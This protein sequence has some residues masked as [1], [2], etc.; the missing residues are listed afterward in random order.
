MEP[1]ITKPRMDR[2][3]ILD[4][5]HENVSGHERGSVHDSEPFTSLR[6]DAQL[7]TKINVYVLRED[8]PL[9]RFFQNG[10]RGF[11]VTFPTRAEVSEGNTGDQRNR[12]LIIKGCP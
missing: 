6:V 11:N 8:K 5:F 2:N 1:G 7:T 3:R 9:A 10:I 4:I 12:D